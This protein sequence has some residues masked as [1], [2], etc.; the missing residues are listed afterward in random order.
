MRGAWIEK[1]ECNWRDRKQTSLFMRGAWIEN[2]NL[3]RTSWNMP[4]ALHAGSV[5]WKRNKSCKTKLD[6]SLPMRGARIEKAFWWIQTE[7][8]RSLTMWGAWIE[9]SAYE[10][11]ISVDSIAPHTRSENW[12]P[13]CNN[14]SERNEC[15]SPYGERELKIQRLM[16]LKEQIMSLPIR[17]A[18][19]EI[20][21]VSS[22]NTAQ[23]APHAGSENWNIDW[24]ILIDSL[25]N[26]SPCRER[27]LKSSN[28][29]EL[30]Y[31]PDIAPQVGSE[32]WNL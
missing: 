13:I 18:R 15:R 14:Y 32:N 7:R 28:Q 21:A 8:I 16:M 20:I 22:G 2:S 29:R 4:V 26:R 5:N 1:S 27:E 30:H 25:K 10:R 3:C 11:K 9:I 24:Y 12:N 19:I 31:L 6:G 17:G 23:I